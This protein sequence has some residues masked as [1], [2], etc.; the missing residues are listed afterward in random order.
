MEIELATAVAAVRDELLDAAAQATATGLEFVVGPI[1]LE[2]SVELKKDAKAKAG[3][4]AWVLS[5]DIEGGVARSNAHRVKV[6]LTARKPGG[7][8]FLVTSAENRRA[9][10]AGDFQGH[11]GR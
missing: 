11:R 9:P 8:E 10:T 5:G 6:A 2:F 7:G 1:E 4:R 3:F